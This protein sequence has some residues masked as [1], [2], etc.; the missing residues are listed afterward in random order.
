MSSLEVGRAVGAAIRAR[1]R[2]A[3]IRQVDLA[4]RIGCSQSTLSRVERGDGVAAGDYAL[5]RAVAVATDPQGAASPAGAVF[6]LALEIE[7]E[8]SVL[9]AAAAARRR[10]PQV[11]AQPDLPGA[12]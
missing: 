12:Q 3:G 8:L 11:S 7:L 6:R 1:R 9:K 2:A 10:G 5:V 4:D